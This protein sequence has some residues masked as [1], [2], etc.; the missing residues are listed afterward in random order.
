MDVY[1]MILSPYVARVIL[2]AR[3]KGIKHKLKM[4]EG[5]IKSP[6]YLM[7]NPLGKMPVIKDG[8]TVLYESGVIVEYLDTK[9]KKK[10]IVPASAA[11]SAKARLIAMIFAEY[12]QA[13]TLL[14]LRQRDPAKYDQKVV[15]EK[16]TEIQRGLDVVEKLLSGKGWAMGSKFSIADV[17]AIPCLFFVTALIPQFGLAEPLGSR[18]KL[19]K[20]VT[21]LSK[22]KLSSVVMS[23]MGEALK[24]FR[25]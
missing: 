17:Y 14:L 2:T 7:M 25:R 18:K 4:P 23:E 12:V 1:G 8:S 22:D 20:Y 5:G 19:K 16:L 6:Q 24:N 13:P 15:E 9:F 11:E 10:R 21:K 3:H